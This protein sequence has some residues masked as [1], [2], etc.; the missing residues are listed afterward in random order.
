MNI[1]IDPEFQ[2]LIRPL[3]EDEFRH[4]ECSVLDDGLID[5]LVVWA[6]DN[7]LL[8]GHHRYRVCQK[9]GLEVKVAPLHFESRADARQWIKDHQLGRRN[10][11]PEQ[12]KY[13]RG[14]KYGEDRRDPEENLQKPQCFSKGQSG[15]S[16]ESQ[17]AAEAPDCTAERL[18][19]EHGVSPRTIKRDAKFAASLDALAD[20]FGPD[21]RRD[22]LGGTSGFSMRDIVAL[23]EMACEG[24]VSAEASREDLK[25]L[26][27]ARKKARKPERT[28]MT[29]E[30]LREMAGAIARA[31]QDCPDTYGGCIEMFE[32]ILKIAARAVKAEEPANA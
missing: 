1:I 6:P 19:K 8:D 14:L 2:S 18:A 9:H 23:A 28:N 21:F 24:L 11:S 32:K 16:G 29:L 30:D 25:A 26:I 13:L 4:L 22:V 31:C 15:P 7:I 27:K 20:I 5:P 12:V 3:T 17:A 10:L